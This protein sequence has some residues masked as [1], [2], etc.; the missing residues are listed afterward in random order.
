MQASQPLLGTHSDQGTDS[1]ASHRDL[2]CREADPGAGGEGLVLVFQ[3]LVFVPCLLLL[4]SP[5][6]DGPV[7]GSQCFQRTIAIHC[8][9][10]KALEIQAGCPIYW[11]GELWS[12]LLHLPDL[13]CIIYKMGFS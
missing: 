6:L 11:W 12:K 4:P 3:R 10:V 5:A 1:C 2:G 9:Q 13:S 7:Q 8:C